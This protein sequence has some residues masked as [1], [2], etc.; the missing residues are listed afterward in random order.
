MFWQWSNWPLVVVVLRKH[1]KIT[2]V[3]LFLI[4]AFVYHKI[5][6]SLVARVKLQQVGAEGSHRSDGRAKYGINLALTPYHA[7]CYFSFWMFSPVI[8]WH[9]AILYGYCIP[10]DLSLNRS[11][12]REHPIERLAWR[13]DPWSGGQERSLLLILFLKYCGSISTNLP[14]QSLFL[15][16]S[17]YAPGVWDNLD[18][19]CWTEGMISNY[20]SLLGILTTKCPYH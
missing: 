14:L 15:T 1:S 20:P 13:T 6:L 11:Y 3:L 10:V 4:T 12:Q 9:W 8:L 16:V 18:T 19:L 17:L 5:D 7:F 2:I